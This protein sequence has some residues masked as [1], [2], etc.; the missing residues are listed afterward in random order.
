[1]DASES[2]DDVF[3]L[4]TAKLVPQALE[5]NLSMYDAHVCSAAQPCVPVAVSPP[6][7]SS[8]DACKA[9]P[10]PQPAIFGAPASATF[11]GTGNIAPPAA[12]P[13]EGEAREM[14]EGL[15]GE[16]AGA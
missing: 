7:C 2:G 10:S 16:T 11:S 15:E 3:F 14:Q 13:R 6:A 1:M 5:N 12:T 9:A 4:T 8:G